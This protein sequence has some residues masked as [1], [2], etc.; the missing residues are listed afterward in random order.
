[1]HV[2]V[3]LHKYMNLC[4]YVYMPVLWPEVEGM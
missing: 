2:C 3:N 4:V 1:M